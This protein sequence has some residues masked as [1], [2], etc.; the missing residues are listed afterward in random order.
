MG[1]GEFLVRQ[2]P[3]ARPARRFCESRP[4]GIVY[5]ACEREYAGKV[6][7]RV[8][9]GNRSPQRDFKI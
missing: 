1:R 8:G 4:S 6:F 3:Q 9:G 5:M 2:C 7:N